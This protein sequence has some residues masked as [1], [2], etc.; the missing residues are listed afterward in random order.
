M[1]SGAP[2]GNFIAAPFKMM[3]MDAELSDT[4]DALDKEA[5][6]Q[7]QNAKNA[8]E[9][10]RYQAGRQ[11]TEATQIFGTMAADVAASNTTQD[12]GSV[13][14]VLRM[15]R[16]N[17]ELDRLNIIRNSEL[18]AQGFKNAAAANRARIQSE[19]RSNKYRK[20]AM[21]FEA[22]GGAAG[23]A[24]GGGSPQPT[25]SPRGGG[26]GSAGGSYRDY[27]NYG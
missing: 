2:M 11:Q 1:G 26:Y 8:L 6:Q 20:T 10:G 19:F 7:D 3:A 5:T 16:T 22:V 17:A 25:A 12:S 27:S 21:F 4:V 15:S 23:S 14:D 18:D 24:Q 13:L 9:A